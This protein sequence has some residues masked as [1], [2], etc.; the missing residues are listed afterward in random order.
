MG[1]VSPLVVLFVA[2]TAACLLT[3]VVQAQ[4]RAVTKT[5]LTVEQA[6]AAVTLTAAVSSE[7]AGRLNGE[8]AFHSSG[9]EL[10]RALLL[11]RDGKLVA[12]FEA[13]LPAGRHPLTARYTGND[14]Y[15]PSGSP[16]VM[17]VRTP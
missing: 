6:G 2:T 10:G 1:R 8:V 3:V 9:K 15:G 5:R 17:V 4:S 12:T 11:P 14:D 7:A 16:M 13:T